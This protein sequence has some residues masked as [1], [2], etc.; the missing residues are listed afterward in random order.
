TVAQNIIDLVENNQIVM[1][2]QGSFPK[3]ASMLAA[4]LRLGVKRVNEKLLRT[5]WRGVL[6]PRPER[7]EQNRS[8]RLDSAIRVQRDGHQSVI[9]PDKKDLPSITAPLWNVSSVRRDLPFVRGP[10]N[11]WT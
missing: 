10:G 3:R 1:A 6:G 7:K 8:S 4:R 2:Q 9:G 11:R 5:G